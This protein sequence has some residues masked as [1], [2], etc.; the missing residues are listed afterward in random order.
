M[1]QVFPLFLYKKS[2]EPPVLR[3]HFFGGVLRLSSFSFL[4]RD[5]GGAFFEREG[6]SYCI[7]IRTF[8]FLGRKTMASGRPLGAF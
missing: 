7:V 4:V 3:L 5:L 6:S 8:F 1:D 2:I